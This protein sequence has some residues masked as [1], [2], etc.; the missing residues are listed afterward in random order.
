MLHLQLA[1]GRGRIVHGLRLMRLNIVGAAVRI[2]EIEH[3]DDKGRQNA[4]HHDIA[5]GQPV[6]D[7][8]FAAAA[9]G[10]DA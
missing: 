1:E 7:R 6:N 10:F 2:A 9:A 4:V 5:E 8:V 3:V